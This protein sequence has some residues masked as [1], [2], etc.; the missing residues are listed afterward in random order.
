MRK[1]TLIALLALAASFF[2]TSGLQAQAGFGCSYNIEANE[3]QDPSG[4]P[5]VNTIVTAVPFL[6]IVPDARAGAMGDVGIATSPDPNAMHFNS[7][8]LAFAEKDLGLSV[9]YT[10]W[11]RALGLNDVYMAYLSGYKK[12]D[13]LQSVGF[14]LRYFSLGDINFTDENGQALGT[15]RPN[16]FEVAGS[17]ARKLGD[18]FSAAVT[19]KFIYSNLAAGQQI[20]NVRINPGT[21]GAAD[22]SFTYRIPMDESEVNLGL[23][24]TNIGTKITYTESINRDFIPANLGFGA[25]WTI[26]FDDYNKLTFAGDVNKLL[27]PTP[28]LG[29]PEE[30]DQTGEEGIPDYREQSMFSG[31]LNSFGDAPGGFDEE[32]R[33]LMYSFGAEYWYDDQFAVRAGYYTEHRTKGNRKF[34]TVGLGLKY[35]IFGLNFSYLVPTTNQRN[36]LDNTLRFSLLFDFEALE[37]E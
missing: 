15:G 19:A 27:V 2:T 31:V 32:I 24:I 23:A 16:E 14:S 33:E 7:S 36:P 9:T 30:C 18:N 12:F 26:N 20:N 4:A 13:E 8:K 25:A 3:W 5:C 17:Y 35:N 11:L 1:N 10:P 29:T 37:G 22:V 6:R 21:A 28:C 34:F